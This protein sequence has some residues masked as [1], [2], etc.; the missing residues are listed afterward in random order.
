[1]QEQE[2]NRGGFT[3][4]EL[5]VVVLIIGIL[6][7]VAVPQYQKAVLKSRFATVKEMAQ[8]LA[9]AEELYYLANGKYTINFEE[10]DISLPPSENEETDEKTYSLRSF[11]DW[12]CR[13][14]QGTTNSYANCGITQTNNTMGFQI[15]MRHGKADFVGERWCVAGQ[16]DLTSLANQV[17]KS[18]TGKEAPSEKD[19]GATWKVWVY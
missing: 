2:L 19:S 4:I 6:A 1:M 16:T 12:R 13:I 9:N 15:Y 8:S 7:A 17:C 3:L 10:L 5:L 14:Y 18:E 11:K